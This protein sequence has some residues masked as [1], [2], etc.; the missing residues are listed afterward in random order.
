M[1]INEVLSIHQIRAVLVARG[2]HLAHNAIEGCL[3]SLSR[4]GLVCATA[5]GFRAAFDASQPFPPQSESDTETTSMTSS[6]EITIHQSASVSISAPAGIHADP[7]HNGIQVATDRIAAIAVEVVEAVAGVRQQL[8]K[9]TRLSSELDELAIHIT[10][11]TDQVSEKIEKLNKVQAL[12]RDLGV[13][14]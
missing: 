9:L 10:L 7:E 6:L 13:A 8:D 1:L 3:H 4:A 11:E 14:G 2:S 5:T 12:L